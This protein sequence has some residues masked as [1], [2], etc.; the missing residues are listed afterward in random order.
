MEGSRSESNGT[1]MMVV[2]NDVIQSVGRRRRRG[3]EE[4]AHVPEFARVILSTVVCTSTGVW[5]G[6]VRYYGRYRVRQPINPSFPALA[7][8]ISLRR[9]QCQSEQPYF[10]IGL[11]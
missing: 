5:I 8:C 10:A 6:G 1:R 9:S 2:S 3:G 4:R 7:K 11:D